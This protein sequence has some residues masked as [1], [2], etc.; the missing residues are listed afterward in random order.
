LFSNSDILAAWLILYIIF[1]V[2]LLNI[3]G[4]LQSLQ[5]VGVCSH[6]RLM[7]V[8]H[9][10]V[11]K[12]ILCLFDFEWKRFPSVCWKFAESVCQ[13]FAEGLLKEFTERIWW[14]F[15]Q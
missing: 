8:S 3:I 11:M 9:I 1:S 6:V 4:K 12:M 13:K 15:L 2:Q 14:K 10:F 7:P 5:A